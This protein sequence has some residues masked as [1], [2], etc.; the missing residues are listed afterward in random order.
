MPVLI[1]PAVNNVDDVEM[2]RRHGD[3]IRL[4]NKK[5]INNNKLKVGTENA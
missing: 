1:I 2:T 5:Y 4:I 3:E